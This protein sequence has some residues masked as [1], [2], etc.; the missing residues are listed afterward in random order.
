MHDENVTDII[1]KHVL[2]FS[3]GL[4]AGFEAFKFSVQNMEQRLNICLSFIPDVQSNAWEVGVRM[5]TCTSVY[6]YFCLKCNLCSLLTNQF[7]P[8]SSAVEFIELMPFVCLC[9]SG[10]LWDLHCAPICGYRTMLY[11]TDLRCVPPTCV[12]HHDAQGGPMSV[13]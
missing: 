4:F 12:V 9:E 10:G 3:S 8:P 2:V 6:K 5:D 7:L 11:T 1:C 13:T